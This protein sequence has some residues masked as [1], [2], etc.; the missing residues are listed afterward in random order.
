VPDGRRFRNLRIARAI[1]GFQR[2]GYRVERVRGSYYI[3]NHPDKGLLVL[4]F[5]RGTVKAG[6]ILDALKKARISVDEFEEVI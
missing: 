3:L 6:I 4:P 2:L 5:H 1:R